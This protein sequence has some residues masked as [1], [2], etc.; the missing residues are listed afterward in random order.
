M[1]MGSGLYNF[2][3]GLNLFCSMIL[4]VLFIKDSC[5]ICDYL[6]MC[7]TRFKNFLEMHILTFM[8]KEALCNNAHI[9]LL[10]YPPPFATL[11]QTLK[12]CNNL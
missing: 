5:E 6:E 2:A 9:F 11:P 8:L 3:V 4:I 12:S 1:G 10:E 7:D